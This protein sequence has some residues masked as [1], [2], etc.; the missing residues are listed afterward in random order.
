MESQN[1]TRNLRFISIFSL[2]LT[3][4]DL[5][6]L[7]LW[8]F[9]EF[10]F[11]WILFVSLILYYS[12][13]LEKQL[14]L[15][16]LSINLRNLE[17]ATYAGLLYLVWSCVRSVMAIPFIL[18]LR[19]N[20]IGNFNMTTSLVFQLLFLLWFALKIGLIVYLIK[21]YKLRKSKLGIYKDA[22]NHQVSYDFN[23]QPEQKQYTTERERIEL[24]KAC[25]LRTFDKNIGLVCSLTY[26]KPE[27]ENTCEKFDADEKELNRLQKVYSKKKKGF[28]NSWKSAILMSVLGFA[29]AGLK[30]FEDPLGIVFLFLGIAWLVIAIFNKDD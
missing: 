5:F 22:N 10:H 20:S 24:C 18:N 9:F 23:K 19:D 28:F 13:T 21:V 17:Y 16:A 15:G 6:N 3:L 26:K 27:F 4:K 1:L 12:I 14:S 8:Y 11:L 2:L 25:N 29:R 30:G 7:N